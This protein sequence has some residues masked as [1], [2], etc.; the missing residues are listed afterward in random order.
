MTSWLSVEHSTQYQYGQDVILAQHLGYLR[1]QKTPWQ[2]V[3]DYQLTIVPN[4]DEL[5]AQIDAFG[6]ERVFFAVTHPHRAL[7][8][9]CTSTIQ[10]DQRY[11]ELDLLNTPSWEI[12]RDSMVYSLDQPFVA[13]SEFVW[14]SPYVPWLALLKDYALP[15]FTH[16]RPIGLAAMDLCQRIFHDFSY[17]SGSTEVHT[18]LEVAF[19]HRKGVCQDFAHIMIGCL[20]ALGLSAKYVSGYLLTKPPEGQERLRGADATHAWVNVYC[21]GV[22]GNWLALDPTNASVADLDH[23]WLAQGRDFG[24][25]SPLRGIIR[26]GGHH[27]LK[28]AVTVEP[29]PVN[30]PS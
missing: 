10:I 2:T 22:A 23:V 8:V 29:A 20:R 19:T 1:P 4:P 26:G 3:T 16:S 14:P 7:D 5:Q 6:N 17:E 15:S 21:P 24:D 27:E 11:A 28:I 25:V 30:H 12:I 18:P 13:A 9:H